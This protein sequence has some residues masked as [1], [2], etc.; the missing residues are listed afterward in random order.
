MKNRFNIVGQLIT[1]LLGNNYILTMQDVLTKYSQGVP[2]VN[3]QAN[4][5]NTEAFT[6][7]FT[8]IHD[9]PGTILTDQRTDFL[10][11]TFTEI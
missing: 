6:V 7:N 1:T 10:S 5:A 2:L 4:T 3:H 8:C 11:K 9:I